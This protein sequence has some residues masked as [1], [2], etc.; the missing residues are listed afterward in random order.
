MAGEIAGLVKEIRPAKEIIDEIVRDA[1]TRL[2]EL[3]GISI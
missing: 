3:Q 2:K 1:N